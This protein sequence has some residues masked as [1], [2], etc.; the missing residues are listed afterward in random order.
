MEGHTLI[1]LESVSLFL[2][3][4]SFHYTTTLQINVDLSTYVNGDSARIE[5]S[6]L[7]RISHTALHIHY[8]SEAAKATA[9]ETE[10]L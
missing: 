1:C 8:S 5:S 9:K 2:E 3:S 4:V 6:G 7:D 10:S